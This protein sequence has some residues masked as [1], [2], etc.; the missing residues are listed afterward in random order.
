[1]TAPTRSFSLKD[2]YRTRLTPLGLSPE[3]HAGV[4]AIVDE[5]IGQVTDLAGAAAVNGTFIERITELLDPSEL[6]RIVPIL[7][8]EQL[9]EVPF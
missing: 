7:E 8:R 2:R 6:A 4:V 5:L 3:Q 9:R 1:M